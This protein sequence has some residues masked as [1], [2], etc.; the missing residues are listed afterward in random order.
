M[1]SLLGGPAIE[2]S[3]ATVRDEV[4]PPH[5][6]HPNGSQ[7]GQANPTDPTTGN[8]VVSFEASG[9]P[10]WRAQSPPLR[11]HMPGGHMPSS[12]VRTKGNNHP[13]RTVPRLP[14]HTDL[15]QGHQVQPLRCN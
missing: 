14:L 15:Y 9:D 8:M 13:V 5:Q 12:Q 1:A 11:G 6:D 10:R 4:P 7:V 2:I 3:P